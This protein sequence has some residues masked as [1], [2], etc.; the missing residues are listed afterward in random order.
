MLR[1][2][3]LYELQRYNAAKA[4]EEMVLK[5]K[6]GY[7]TLFEKIEENDVEIEFLKQKIIHQNLEI[8]SLENR[9]IDIVKTYKFNTYPIVIEINKE[10]I[11]DKIKNLWIYKF[12]RKRKIKLFIS[13]IIYIY[14]KKIY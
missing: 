5:A 11:K 1:K 14:F 13:L 6:G 7:Y 3:R 2:R 4:H 9:L 8:K 10:F 12:I